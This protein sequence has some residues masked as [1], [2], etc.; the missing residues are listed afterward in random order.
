MDNSSAPETHK[1]FQKGQVILREGQVNPIAFMV[2]KGAVVLYRLVNNRRVVVAH[3]KPGQIFG[4]MALITGEPSNATAEAEVHT[5]VITFDRIF[6]QSLLLKC[7]NPIQRMVRQFMEQ[8]RTMHTLV[9]ERPYTD[10][11]LSICQLLELFSQAQGQYA[12]EEHRS[13]MRNAV[14]YADFVRACKTVLLVAQHEIDA[15]VDKLNKLNLVKVRDVKGSTYKRDILGQVSKSTEYLRDQI[16]VISD[17]P[18]FMSVAKNLRRELSSEDDV[19]QTEA[20]EYIDIHDLAQRAAVEEGVLYRLICQR[21]LPDGMLCFPREVADAWVRSLPEDY[22]TAQ[23]AL[24]SERGTIADDIVYESNAAL[25][26]AFSNL[27]QSKVLVLYVAAGAAAKQK[28]MENVSKK[29]RTVLQEESKRFR[30]DLTEV[31]TVEEE[32]YGLLG[33]FKKEA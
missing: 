15:V 13:G 25:Q 7:P 5:E 28:I 26:L 10:I 23:Q 16:I 22:F 21:E 19:G 9:Q 31:I 14:S 17:P 27:G 3:L 8:L 11:F 6:L 4:E 32:L 1:T 18:R 33:K 29:M 30:V 20:M 12:P 2:K 24:Q